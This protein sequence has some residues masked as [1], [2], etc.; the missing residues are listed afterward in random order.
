MPVRNLTTPIAAAPT[1]RENPCQWRIVGLDSA[2]VCTFCGRPS[3]ATCGCPDEGAPI[4]WQIGICTDCLVDSIMTRFSVVK[5][6]RT[7]A[8]ANDMTRA[9]N[10]ISAARRRAAGL[11]RDGV[12]DARAASGSM[13]GRAKMVVVR[14]TV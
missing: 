6:Q 4:L 9:S 12:D 5:H 14:A 2:P 13:K 3:T 8:L 7:V 10:A 11:R 1:S